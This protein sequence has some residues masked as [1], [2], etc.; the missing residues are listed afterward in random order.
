[1]AT[2]LEAKFS[3]PYTTAYTLLHGPPTVRSFATVDADARALANGRIVVETDPALGEPEFRLRAGDHELAHVTAARG[4]PQHPQTADD[5]AAK[6][7][8]LAG[9]RLD[10]ALDDLERPAGDVLNA[11]ADRGTRSAH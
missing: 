6:V 4:S 5:L 8:D 2:P 10:G 7:R 11:L 9:G 1:V 3:I